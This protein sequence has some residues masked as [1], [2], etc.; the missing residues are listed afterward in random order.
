[1]DIK[2][3]LPFLLKGKLG[4]NEQAILNLSQ[5]PDPAAL[6]TLF[7]KLYDSKQ[8]APH[9]DL[10]AALKRIIPAETLGAVIK[11][12]DMQRAERKN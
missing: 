10:M 2:Q 8:K 4:E 5:N 3:M 12:F 9:P 7:T 6:H 1:M 11:Y